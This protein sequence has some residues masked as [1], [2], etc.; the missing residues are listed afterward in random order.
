MNDTRDTSEEKH[1]SAK[2]AAAAS[3]AGAV[4]DWYDFY[5]YGLVAALA[6]PKLFFPSSEPVTATLLTFATFGVGF[7]ARPIGGL[8]FG[9]FGDKLGRKKMLVL[10]LILMGVGTALVSVLPTFAQVGIAAPVLLVALRFVQGFAVGG[11]WGGAALMAIEHSPK[12]RRG[13]F[14]SF[15][16][17]GASVGLLIATGVVALINLLTT[18]AQFLSWGWRIPFLLSLLVVWGGYLIR[19]NVDESPEF[20]QKVEVAHKVDKVPLFTAISQNPG[21][22]LKI[23]GMRLAELVSFYIVTVFALNYGSQNLGIPRA[24]LL[25]ATLLIGFVAIPLIPAMGALSDRIGRRPVFVAGALVGALGAFP[26]FWALG[27][28]NVVLI[29]LAFVLVANVCHDPVVAVQQPLFTEMFEP[30]FRYSGAGLAYQL[31]S[32]IAGGLT[33]FIAAALVVYNDGGYTYVAGYLTAAC[34]ISALIGLRWGGP[35][36]HG[37]TVGDSDRFERGTASVA[38]SGSASH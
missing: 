15:V 16:Q 19:R 25:N 7:V 27:T 34:L 28:H 2:R 10:T 29:T 13:F 24:T 26:L 12:K 5:A 9:H 32:A 21:A 11:E 8:V 6:F 30:S 3:F 23:I 17:V 37:D 4:M 31:A 35:Q 14:G 18:E 22:F 1:T 36:A 20:V 33:P 38:S